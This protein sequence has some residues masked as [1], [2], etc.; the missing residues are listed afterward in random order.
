MCCTVITYVHHLH[1]PQDRSGTWWENDPMG[2]HEVTTQKTLLTKSVFLMYSMLFV[3]K[4]CTSQLLRFYRKLWLHM[5]AEEYPYS[6]SD[7]V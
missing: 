1:Q 4:Y 3:S 6:Y 7:H 5:I 2:F